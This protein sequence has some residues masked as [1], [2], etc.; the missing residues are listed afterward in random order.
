MADSTRYQDWYEKAGRDLHG[1][2]ILLEHDGGNDLVAFHCQQA[3]EKHLK[4]WLLKNT[5][6]LE[7][8]HS[9]VYLCRKA[10]QLGAPISKRLRDCAY[11]NQFY[12]ET[13][14]PSDSYIP[15]SE[16]EALDCIEV[17]EL[18]IKELQ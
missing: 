9:L 2:K 16:K 1:A 13:R 10:I 11:V 7:D 15:V 4:G 3:M 8:G 17:A 6:E 14:Y 5:S 12:I 18:L